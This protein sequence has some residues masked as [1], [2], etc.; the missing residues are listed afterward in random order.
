MA[1]NSRRFHAPR[2]PARYALAMGLGGAPLLL[3]LVLPVAAL[4]GQTRPDAWLASALSPPA[5]DALALSLRTSGT[6]TLLAVGLGTPLAYVLAKGSVPAVWARVLSILVDLPLI[7]PPVVAGVALLLVFGRFGWLG[8]RLYEAGLPLAFTPTAVVLAQ[9]FVASPFF[10]RSA[11]LGLERIDPELENASA[12]DGASF[13]QTLAYVTLPL[14]RNALL[15]GSIMTWARALG[16]FGA[17]LMFAGN[18]PG[19]TQT[20]PMVIY[21]GFD[22][23]ASVSLA[24]AGVL[25]LVALAVLAATR[26]IQARWLRVM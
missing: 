20:L 17:T 19:L 5:R 8:R 25:L 22:L 11:A 21:L 12:L 1:G 26:L 6:A 10:V 13:A 18:M 2:H 16:E 24:L 3:F 23:D 9:L 14:T 7:L 4:L 15:T